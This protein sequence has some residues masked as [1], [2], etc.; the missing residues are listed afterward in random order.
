MQKSEA[1]TIIGELFG[2][3]Y[4][5]EP[6]EVLEFINFVFKTNIDLP[7]LRSLA[8]HVKAGEGWKIKT[9][10]VMVKSRNSVM[11]LEE[12]Y[13]TR[14]KRFYSCNSKVFPTKI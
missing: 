3:N 4:R 6:S 11:K 2:H 8:N 10:K 7:Q 9:G 14:L 5:P 12:E 13:M 1:E